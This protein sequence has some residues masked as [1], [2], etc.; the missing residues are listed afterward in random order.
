M[1]R[2]IKEDRNET[3]KKSEVEGMKRLR[4]KRKRNCLLMWIEGWVAHYTFCPSELRAYLC[5]GCKRC[6]K[7]LR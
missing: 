2:C 4:A 3:K 1:K 6:P 7:S 5:F